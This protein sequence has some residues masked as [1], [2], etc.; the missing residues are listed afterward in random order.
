MSTSIIL[1]NNVLKKKLKNVIKSI[2]KFLS[3]SL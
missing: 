2:K 3:F 1:G